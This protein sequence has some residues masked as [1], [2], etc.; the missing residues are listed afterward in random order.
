MKKRLR[1]IE[2][3]PFLCEKDETMEV[4]KLS[5][6]CWFFVNRYNKGAI[7]A[8]DLGKISWCPNQTLQWLLCYI[9]HFVR[10]FQISAVLAHSLHDSGSWVR[11]SIKCN[12]LICIYCSYTL[13]FWFLP[14][15]QQVWVFMLSP[16]Q[17][18]VLVKIKL[19]PTFSKLWSA[20]L[21]WQ[22][23]T[24]SLAICRARP[25]LVCRPKMVLQFKFSINFTTLL[26][27]V[28]S[29]KFNLIFVFEV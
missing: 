3:K 12:L 7:V 13:A 27:L 14:S 29:P 2:I 5:L 11:G 25:V 26:L 21:S 22:I 24:W 10:Q 6:E 16:F 17:I 23:L 1:R 4:S 15:A 9:C 28:L 8:F 20:T 18:C 19:T